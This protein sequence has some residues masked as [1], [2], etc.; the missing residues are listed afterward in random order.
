MKR[1]PSAKTVS[2]KSAKARG[3]ESLTVAVLKQFR[4]IY[5]NVRQH[6]RDVE[7]SCGIS[8]SQL[9]VIR[10]IDAAPGI[11]VSA[12]AEKLSIHQSTCSQL[13][14]TLV[15]SGYVTKIRMKDDQRRVGLTLAKRGTKILKQ[16]PG[17]AEGVLPQALSQLPD[18]ALSTLNRNLEKLIAELRVHDKRHAAKLL[19]DL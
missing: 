4:L 7:E 16:A 15:G 8:G 5:G 9:W 6:F 2:K 12:L 13:V 18:A 10:E 14:E 19:A 1:K 17:P 3:H 11:G